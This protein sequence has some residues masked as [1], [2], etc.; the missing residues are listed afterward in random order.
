MSTATAAAVPTTRWGAWPVAALL[1]TVPLALAAG[2][3]VNASPRLLDGNQFGMG[4]EMGISTSRV[5]ARGPVGVRGDRYRSGVGHRHGHRAHRHHAGHV[6]A[7]QHLTNGG[8]KRLP[9]VVGLGPVQLWVLV[10]L[11]VAVFAGTFYAMRELFKRRSG[12]L[13]FR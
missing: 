9:A 3:L 8:G 6:E 10:V 5:H 2:V 11:G 12:G 13:G 7:L 4:A 1:A